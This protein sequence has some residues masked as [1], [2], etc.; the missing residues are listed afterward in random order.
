MRITKNYNYLR[1][2]NAYCPQKRVNTT[3]G[4][5]GTIKTDVVE[6]SNEAR[7]RV[8]MENYRACNIEREIYDNAVESIKNFN[9]REI[10]DNSVECERD[11]AVSDK[12]LRQAADKMLNDLLNPWWEM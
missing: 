11:D 2:L 5:P 4:H 6:I 8:R 12:I 9:I 7:E 1:I 3:E 10:P